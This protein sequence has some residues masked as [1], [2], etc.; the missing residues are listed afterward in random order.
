MYSAIIIII[1]III[2]ISPKNS[3]CYMF[4]ISIPLFQ[5]FNP[6]FSLRLNLKLL[7]TSTFYRVERYLHVIQLMKSIIGRNVLWQFLN[8]FWKVQTETGAKQ[9][10]F[11]FSFSFRSHGIFYPWRKILLG[12]LLSSV[13]EKLKCVPYRLNSKTNGQLLLFK[14][15]FRACGIKTV[16]CRLF[17]QMARMDMN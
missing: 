4:M 15:I 5:S 10:N 2:I 13:F 7:L 17:I 9:I 8:S 11:E 14:T 6:L 16:F 12:Y 3:I 1:I